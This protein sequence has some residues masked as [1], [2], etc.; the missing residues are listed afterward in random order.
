MDDFHFQQ[1]SYRRE[2]EEQGIRA[3]LLHDQGVVN[4]RLAP[5]PLLQLSA[6]QLTLLIPLGPI[7]KWL[8]RTL[9]LVERLRD[10]L[11]TTVTVEVDP[12]LVLPKQDAGTVVDISWTFGASRHGTLE[13]VLRIG[14]NVSIATRLCEIEFT[15]VT[16]LFVDPTHFVGVFGPGAV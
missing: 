3:T 12:L 11:I 9:R 7:E 6:G 16:I 1:S 2:K 10:T 8:E 15:T 13:D 14:I 4:N 5:L